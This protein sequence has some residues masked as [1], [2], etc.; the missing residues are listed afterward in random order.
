MDQ[1]LVMVGVLFVA[2]SSCAGSH[3]EQVRDARLEGIEAS[4]DAKQERA[5]NRRKQRQDAIDKRYD[6]R[7]ER[8]E[9][10]NRPVAESQAKLIELRKERADFRSQMQTRLEKLAVRINAAHASSGVG[11]G[12]VTTT[13][14]A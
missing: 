11:L 10:S 13:S 3:A 2:T 5:D 1:R 7:Q 6:A 4:A 12:A 14:S 8:V 9:D